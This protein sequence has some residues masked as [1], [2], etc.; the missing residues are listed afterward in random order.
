[1]VQNRPLTEQLAVAAV[2]EIG[3]Q[4]EALDRVQRRTLR[5]VTLAL[6]IL[7]DGTVGDVRTRIESTEAPAAS[8]LIERLV[9]AAV[10]AIRNEAPTINADPG[11]LRGMVLDLKLRPAGSGGR[12]VVV[13][14]ATCYVERR[15]NCRSRS[16]GDR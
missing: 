3:T 10:A 16:E 4:R 13:E 14:G 6:D 2:R 15:A 9:E 11:A 8:P 1:M 7:P 12:A 5:R